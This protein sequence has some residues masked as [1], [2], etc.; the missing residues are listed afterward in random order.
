MCLQFTGDYNGED[1]FS[2][3]IGVGGLLNADKINLVGIVLE[4]L[5]T[6]HKHFRMSFKYADDL[7][8]CGGAVAALTGQPSQPPSKDAKEVK[9][10][11]FTFLLACGARLRVERK[12]KR[13]ESVTLAA[14]VPDGGCA[15]GCENE[16]YW[17]RE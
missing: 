15:Q 10:C 17:S 12:K 2:S 6:F 7:H 5:E 16:L 4:N 13:F 8:A 3:R 11:G 9:G 14:S 1:H